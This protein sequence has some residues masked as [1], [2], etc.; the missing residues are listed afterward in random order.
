MQDD[1]EPALFGVKALVTQQFGSCITVT[2]PQKQVVSG[3]EIPLAPRS[4]NGV[5]SEVVVCSEHDLEPK[6]FKNIGS[7]LSGEVR[8][9]VK[10]CWGNGAGY[11]HGGEPGQMLCDSDLQ[12]IYEF[13]SGS[14]CR[15][16][17]CS[18]RRPW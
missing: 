9:L 18:C 4:W 3:I 12:I 11:I 10:A 6:Q 16:T 7:L 1:V 17:S 2:V 13:C 8:F 5:A 15:Q 14:T